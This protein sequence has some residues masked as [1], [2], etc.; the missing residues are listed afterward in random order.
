VGF[1]AV[2]V[3]LSLFVVISTQYFRR[4]RARAAVQGVV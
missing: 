3:T 4:Q 2:L 1:G